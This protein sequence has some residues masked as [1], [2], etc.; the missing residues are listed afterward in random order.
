MLNAT[1]SS[2]SMPCASLITL[3]DGVTSRLHTHSVQQVA[4]VEMYRVSSQNIGLTD[5]VE[6]YTAYHCRVGRRTSPD[7]HMRAKS[8]IL[9]LLI[10]LDYNAAGKKS[11][12]R[13]DVAVCIMVEQERLVQSDSFSI[14]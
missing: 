4:D 3:V 10:A 2:R 1:L 6:F 13:F 5:S 9:R 8:L 14:T 7:N 11:D 12:F